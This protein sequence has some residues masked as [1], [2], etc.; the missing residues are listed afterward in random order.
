[1][2]TRWAFSL[3][4][5]CLSL[6]VHAQ[7]GAD[8]LGAPEFAD[9]EAA[10]A[11]AEA[12]ADT[13]SSALALEVHAGTAAPL[14]VF[15]AAN[16]VIG[17]YLLLTSSIGVS[18]YRN[19]VDSVA[20]RFGSEESAQ[21]VTPLL[22]GATLVR[23][24]LGLRPFGKGGPELLAGYMRIMGS[25]TWEAGSFGIPAR[26]GEISASVGINSVYAELGW[27]IAIG[28]AFVRPAIGFA[29]ALGTRVAVSAEDAN[30]AQTELTSERAGE[31]VDAALDDFGM[32]P[33][34]SISIGGHFAF[35][36]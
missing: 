5:S 20:A 26:F 30:A 25:A 23:L 9:A 18:V 2:R 14:D 17:E 24:G 3:V 13:P 8:E 10:E 35:N 22:F 12:E 16:V 15:V 36:R 27:S 32:M 31:A 1:M 11:E 28:N 34:V 7:E 33:T 6:Q 29:R 19:T 21:V 4:L